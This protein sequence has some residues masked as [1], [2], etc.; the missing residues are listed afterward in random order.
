MPPNTST[1][2]Y[3]H[4]VLGLIFLKYISD[5]FQER[6]DALKQEPYADPED[7]DE[8]TS[9]GVFWV[10]AEAR[11]STI[12]DRAKLPQIGKTIDDAMAAIERANPTSLRN[13]LPKD[14]A[15]SAVSEQRIAELIDLIGTIGLG[16]ASS[17]AQDILG[18]VYEYVLGKFAN[19][20][21]KAGGEFYT[22]R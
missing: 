12:Q 2:E 10:P 22:P 21:G 5:A 14:Y 17:R 19:A 9:A 13:V 4:I 7:R 6:H 11:W 18:R 15:R 8:Y 20:E 16:D 1:S 3:K